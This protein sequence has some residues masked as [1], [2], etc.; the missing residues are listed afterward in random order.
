MSTL[1]IYQY[2]RIPL[3]A[4]FV[5]TGCT[6]TDAPLAGFGSDISGIFDQRWRGNLFRK[7]V[8]LKDWSRR[9]IRPPRI[10]YRPRPRPRAPTNE[11]AQ[12]DTSCSP[13]G[14][15]TLSIEARGSYGAL[16]AGTVE[17]RSDGNVVGR[18]SV[19]SGIT[20]PSGCPL[21]VRVTFVDL[22]DDP[23]RSLEE[24]SVSRNGGVE[25]LPLVIETGMLRIR[26]YSD[27]RRISGVARLHR[28]DPHTT[29]A[30]AT[31]SATMAA[32]N[33]SREISTGSY[34]VRL[35]YRG[36]TLRTTVAVESGRSRL[37]TLRD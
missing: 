28:V 17:L 3:L 4:L 11:P 10:S 26:A 35:P 1:P 18:G 7:T 34:E 13:N 25:S 5:T 2:A 9:I 32:N 16:P 15:G 37:V 20:V 6:S 14:R 24:V 29:R 31:P 12:P 22:A 30:E 21:D 27:G 36:R 23:V 19:Y 8:V 33:V